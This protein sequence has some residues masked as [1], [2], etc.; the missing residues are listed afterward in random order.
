MVKKSNDFVIE[1]EI[2]EHSENESDQASEE[3]DEGPSI[4]LNIEEPTRTK[5]KYV[6]TEARKLALAKG[7]E[8]RKQNIMLRKNDL[9]E[10]KLLQKK[11]KEDKLTKKVMAEL[12]NDDSETE[13]EIVKKVKKNIKKS[14]SKKKKKK[15]IVESS[16]ES[17]SEEEEVYKKKK[18]TT[19]R[20]E[21]KVIEKYDK[22]PAVENTNTSKYSSYF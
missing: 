5:K 17:E 8:T 10:L 7:R 16:S 6:F 18:P 22:E 4:T 15:I 14:K 9:D 1:K 3:E 11:N 21:K 20:K 2:I 19:K 12:D 13:D